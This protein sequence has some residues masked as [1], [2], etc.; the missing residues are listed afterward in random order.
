VIQDGFNG[1]LVETGK[2]ELFYNSVVKLIESNSLR[3]DFGKA[4]RKTIEN[5]YSEKAVINHY[6]YWI[7]NS[8]K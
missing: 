1:F 8:F 7:G 6:L 4:L 5:D 3:A 2:I